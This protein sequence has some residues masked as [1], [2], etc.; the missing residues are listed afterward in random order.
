MQQQVELQAR[1]GGT[2]IASSHSAG[3]DGQGDVVDHGKVVG[4]EEQVA[5]GAHGVVEEGHKKRGRVHMVAILTALFVCWL[6]SLKLSIAYPTAFY[7][8]FP[9]FNISPIQPLTPPLAPPL[10]RRPRRH[11]CR[12]RRPNHS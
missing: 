8:N 9:P 4:E 11:Y 12:H 3:G 5:P 7:L 1:G 10:R 6:A 2:A